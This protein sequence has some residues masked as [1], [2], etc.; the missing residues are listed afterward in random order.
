MQ[1]GFHR[2]SP[3][4][5][6][7]VAMT[8][9]LPSSEIMALL[10]RPGIAAGT[11]ILTQRGARGVETLLVGDKV[12]TRDHG[13]QAL[14]WIGLVQQAGA[15]RFEAG[16]LGAH[17]EITL[18]PETRVLIRNPLVKVLF[19]EDEVFARARD[20]V[21]GR[22]IRL[23][24]DGA[25][26]MVQLLFDQHEILRAA[27]MEVESLQPEGAL[28]SQLDAATKAEIARILPRAAA[29]YSPS[30]R[31]CLRRA[32]ARMFSAAQ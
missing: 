26:P 20:L 25:V 19:G 27:E 2:F 29:G 23:L 1:A 3:F 4:P 10:A 18:A 21:N 12:I 16:A 32:E 24:E 17:D 6:I 30:A 28:S 13:F 7:E 9:A 11:E 15:I 5:A 22:S 8:L 31:P 14:R